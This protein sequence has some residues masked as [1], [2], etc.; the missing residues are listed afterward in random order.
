MTTPGVEPLAPFHAHVGDYFSTRDLA[1]RLL[2]NY[3]GLCGLTLIAVFVV[4]AMMAP[5]ISPHDPLEQ[6]VRAALLPPSSDNW[7][8]TDQFGR[9]ILSRIIHGTRVSLMVGLM[10][11]TVAGTCGTAL[12]MLAGFYQGKLDYVVSR[13]ADVMLAFPGILLA[14]AVVAVIGPSLFGAIGAVAFSTI[15]HYVRLAR[16]SVLT[17]KQREYV[18]ASRALGAGDFSIMAIHIFRNILPPILVLA[19]L[20]VGSGILAAAALSFLGLGAQPPTPEWGAMLSQARRYI[21]QA[22]WITVFPGG[23][24]MLVVLGANLF[25]DGLRD[26]LDPRL[27]GAR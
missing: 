12:G 6:N 23:A 9:D 8:G 27:K 14:L 2:Q 7:F 16:G 11:V 15:P 13:V 26:V 17:E 18:V 21:R 4:I 20:G 24:I 5:Y 1:V 3:S 25:G 22:W 10:I 19:T